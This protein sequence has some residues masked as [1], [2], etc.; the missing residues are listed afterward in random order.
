MNDILFI[1]KYLK[2]VHAC[3]SELIG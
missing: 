2:H 1:K 3:I